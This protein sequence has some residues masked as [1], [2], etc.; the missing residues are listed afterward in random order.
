[1]FA[2]LYSDCTYGNGPISLNIL[3]FLELSMKQKHK[4]SPPY[5]MF[6]YMQDGWTDRE[7]ILIEKTAGGE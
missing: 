6:K 7:D 2:E 3:S 4:N 1:M 5:T